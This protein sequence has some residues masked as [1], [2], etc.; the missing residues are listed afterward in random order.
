MGDR[1]VAI[2]YTVTVLVYVLLLAQRHLAERSGLWAFR[3]AGAWLLIFAGF[4]LV[5]YWTGWRLP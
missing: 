4:L 5:V 3:A 2:A 1:A